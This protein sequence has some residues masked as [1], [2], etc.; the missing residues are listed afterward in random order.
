MDGGPKVV[1]RGIAAARRGDPGDEDVVG[2]VDKVVPSER[3]DAVVLAA[4]MRRCDGSELPIAGRR[5]QRRGSGHERD[6]VRGEQRRRNQDHRIVAD[7]RLLDDG[8]D[9]SGVTN[10]ELVDQLL[11]AG[12]W[13]A[14]IVGASADTSLTRG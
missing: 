1:A 13:H 2:M 14:E 11:T 4:Q 7:P 3:V 6:S 8:F 12:R 10:H 5:G 9:R